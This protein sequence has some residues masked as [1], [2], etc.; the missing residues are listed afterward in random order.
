M[1][2]HGKGRRLSLNRKR[3]IINGRNGECCVEKIQES[4]EEAAATIASDSESAEY[5]DNTDANKVELFDQITMPCEAEQNMQI[6]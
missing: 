6:H 1:K 5:E 2:S 4:Q 3:T